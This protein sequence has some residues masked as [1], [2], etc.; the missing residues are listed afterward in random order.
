MLENWSI[1]AGRGCVGFDDALGLVSGGF[2]SAPTTTAAPCGSLRQVQYRTS[3][4][5]SALNHVITCI[6]DD[7]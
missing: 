2:F 1:A 3:M 6:P 4:F 5:A 7:N